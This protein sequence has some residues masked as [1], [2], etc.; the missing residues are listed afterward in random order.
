MRGASACTCVHTHYA[1]ATKLTQVTVGQ[2]S[3]P[4]AAC[5][6]TIDET[7]LAHSRLDDAQGN[8]IGIFCTVMILRYVR[9]I[10]NAQRDNRVVEEVFA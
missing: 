8:G 10:D 1:T 7:K 2:Q 6:V 9:G 3:C 4:I 5:L